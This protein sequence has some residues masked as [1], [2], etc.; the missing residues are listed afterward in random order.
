MMPKAKYMKLSPAAK[1]KQRAKVGMTLSGSGDYRVSRP[2]SKA[3]SASRTLRGHG[4][5]WVGPGQKRADSMFDG[6]AAKAGESVFGKPGKYIGGAL[7]GLFKKLTGVGDYKVSSNSIM[8]GNDPPLFAAKGSRGMVVQHR[9][10]L[11]DIITSGTAGAFN[12][13]Q[14]PLNAGQFATFPWLS[15]IAQQY[16][17]YC[18]RGM[19]FEFK[20]MSSDALNSVNTALGSVV[21]ATQYNSV[22][23]PFVNKSQMEN[24]EFSS[25][26]KSSCDGIHAIECARG[27]TPV[28][29]LY[30]RSGPVP[31]NADARLYDLGQFFIATVGFQGTSVNIGELWCSYDIEFLKPQLPVG[32]API[33]PMDHW[34]S[35][36]GNIT[37]TQYFGLSPDL[38]AGNTGTVLS[39]QTPSASQGQLQFPNLNYVQGYVV[40]YWVVG[41]SAVLTLPLT[42][43]LGGG[44]TST[45][46]YWLSNSSGIQAQTAGATAVTQ[47]ISQHVV[48]PANSSSATWTITPNCTLPGGTITQFDLTVIR[49][50]LN[51]ESVSLRAPVTKEAVVR[52]TPR[53]SLPFEEGDESS[54]GE[55][56]T[57]RAMIEYLRFKALAKKSR[58]EEA[59][60]EKSFTVVTEPTTPDGPTIKA[61]PSVKTSKK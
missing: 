46:V 12:I 16:E 55:E 13:Q 53:L 34:V 15:T 61:P 51:S 38:L 7:Q 8:M 43:I 14:F 49:A 45:G 60:E 32:G 35:G 17:Q 29:C 2:R 25:S 40:T 23:P 30:V 4:D 26:F 54:D 1:A 20:S 58:R 41:S 31:L 28:N 24:H 33:P 21:L 18:I 19:V 27:E 9:E 11:G 47:F 42:P 5:Y 50:G 39:F 36:I 44:V 48:V 3:K 6:A 56:D 22:S 52:K 59:K 10:Y 37:N 57:E